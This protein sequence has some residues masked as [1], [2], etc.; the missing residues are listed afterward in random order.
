MHK[1]SVILMILAS[2]LI[3][4]AEVLTPEAALHRAT[5][6]SR[7]QRVA[8]KF[9][10]GTPKLVF[11]STAD[12]APTSYVFNYDKGGFAVLAAD[13]NVDAILGFADNGNIDSDNLPPSFQAWLKNCDAQIAAARKYNFKPSQI[14][15]PRRDNISPLLSTRWSQKEPYHNMCPNKYPTGCNATAA[16]QVMKYY[17]WPKKGEGEIYYTSGDSEYYA[18]FSNT[19]YDWDNMLN[20]YTAGDETQQQQDAVALLMYHCGIAM[21]TNYGKNESG[22]S[23]YDLALALIENFSYDKSLVDIQRAYFNT[24]DWEE[25]IYNQLA[26][27]QPVMY[28]GYELDNSGHTFVCDGYQDCGYFHINWGWGGMSDGYFRLDALDPDM[29]GT[30]GSS[31]GY[32]MDQEIIYNIKPAQ[33]ESSPTKYI[34]IQNNFQLTLKNE[35]YEVENTGSGFDNVQSALR[36]GL[37]FVVSGFTYN[38]SLYPVSGKFGLKFVTTNED[39]E[40]VVQYLT[41]GSFNN[42]AHN[43]GY[44]QFTIRTKS[45]PN[46]SEYLKDGEYKVTPV[47][48]DTETEEWNKI[49]TVVSGV[50]SYDVTVNNGRITATPSDYYDIA[51]QDFKVE[52][53]L[54]NSHKF[55]VRAKII[56]N[57]DKEFISELSL[58]VYSTNGE[59]ITESNDDEIIYVLPNNSEEFEIVTNFKKIIAPGKCKLC[60]YNDYLDQAVGDPIDVEIEQLD[61]ETMIMVHN[62]SFGGL[63]PDDVNQ[64]AIPYSFIVTCMQGYILEDC[65]IYLWKEDKR[66]LAASLTIPD[67]TL[68]GGQLQ[69]ISGTYDFEDGI[70]GKKYY[71]SIWFNGSYATNY[72]YPITL[73]LNPE[74]PHE[75]NNGVTSVALDQRI[76]DEQ[77]Y[78]L[79]GAPV[80]NPGAGLY[81][82]VTTHADGHKTSQKV[83]L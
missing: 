34:V 48:Y 28:S 76:T 26:K 15:R 46:D 56:N 42:L 23:T 45:N 37:Q 54:Y 25:L 13:D 40:E 3:C 77:Y 81:I 38:K 6:S 43:K 10:Q 20:S 4:N 17:E 74:N 72:I 18:D 35:N 79:Q 12:E 64:H 7:S 33:A 14:A 36:T 52:T 60:L 1:F 8:A 27:G 16:A 65:I 32:N 78:N 21:K 49:L 41:G 29:Q 71:G 9:G 58:R 82:K 83:K 70:P 69:E 66:T 39:G 44:S 19:Y 51:V 63:T 57:G 5:T 30:G 75:D 62:V 2:A 50:T 68:E 53:K 47:W 24:L 59:F 22:A 55:K 73:S 11:T 31:L 67:I 61:E 80:T